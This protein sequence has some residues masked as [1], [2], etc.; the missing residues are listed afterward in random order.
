MYLST[1]LVI[2]SKNNTLDMRLEKFHYLHGH[3]I[4]FFRLGVFLW[5]KK[6]HLDHNSNR[7]DKIIIK[8]HAFSSNFYFCILQQ[9]TVTWVGIVP[10]VK[11]WEF[12]LFTSATLIAVERWSERKEIKNKIK[13]ISFVIS[14][15]KRHEN[16]FVFV[17]PK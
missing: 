5:M 10:D 14:I 1:I 16:T 17:S 2:M 12:E 6:K 8:S 3:T 11:L 4:I 15:F 13:L 9:I 7:N